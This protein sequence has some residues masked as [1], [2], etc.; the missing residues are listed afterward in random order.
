MAGQRSINDIRHSLHP[1][2][3]ADF[4]TTFGPS[5]TDT[6]LQSFRTRRPS[7]FRVNTLKSDDASVL[8]ELRG[9]KYAPRP[10]QGIP[11]AFFLDSDNAAGLLKT[12]VCTE[13]R[14]YLQGLSSMLPVLA[15]APQAGETI[16]DLCASPGSKTSQIAAMIGNSGRIAAVEPDT[17]RKER[18]DHNLRLL[19]CVSV[20]SFGMAG[21]TFC[22]DRPDSFDRV[23]VDAPCSG[24]GR[25]SVYEPGS[26]ASWNPQLVRKCAATQKKLL[27]S[28]CHAVKPG[29][30]VL[31]STCTLN[32][33]E[34]EAICDACLNDETC[35][36]MIIADIPRSVITASRGIPGLTKTPS[37]RAF[38]PSLTKALRILPSGDREGF[39]LCLL[40]KPPAS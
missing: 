19:G 1:E 32:T 25:F 7:S 27:I 22:R 24:E 2:V 38:H 13:G 5:A 17:I 40:H 6:L 36:A 14:I 21:S 15:L 3:L 18:L 31:Y 26:F 10:I 30:F 9:L 4:I 16:L 37:G 20:E 28:A 34:N 33:A 29:G 12:R 8:A 23:L 11:H 39:F 35:P